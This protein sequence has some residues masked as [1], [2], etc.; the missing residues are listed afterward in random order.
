MT[1]PY[2]SWGRSIPSTPS[3]VVPLPFAPDALPDS[4]LLI[5]YGLG[6]SYGDVCLNNGH[7]LL[8][9]GRMDHFRRFDASTGILECEAGTSLE[10]ILRIGV[11]RG[12]FP[13]VTPGTKFVTVG[14]C[15]ANDV[16]GKNHHRA[17]TFGRHVRSLTL[18]RS[19]GLRRLTPDDPLFA[20]TIGGLGLTGLIVSAEI[21]LRPIESP[22]IVAEKIPFRT[23]EEFDALSR[24]SD[25]TH[26]Y[27]VAWFDSFGGRN[28]RGI[29]FRG[30][31]A[32]SS[33]AAG[34]QPALGAPRGA[35]W[36]PAL[37]AAAPFL[38]PFTV[39][40]FNEAYFR[41]NGR[42]RPQ[43]IDFDPFFYPLDAV[44]DWN[45]IYGKRGFLQ[46]QFVTPDGAGLAP[47]GEVLDRVAKSGLASFLTVI[48]RFGSLPSPGLI[49]FPREGITACFDF[50][51]S[52]S[53]LYAMLDDLDAIVLA[54]GGAIYPAKDARMSA[55]TFRRSFPQ[56]ETFA[57]FIDPRFSS[58]FR[59]RVAL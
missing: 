17:G 45:A 56:W 5:P 48:K 59:R 29:F 12:W 10:E 37:H 16:H 35:G 8:D 7:T 13:P 22:S 30:N 49:S 11:P 9:S 18:L 34:F 1:M 46:Y 33:C 54:A 26:D 44:A 14:G 3:R 36:K 53:G 57:R 32:P 50:A 25:A 39:R 20:A 51:A 24:A 21:A 47:V 55:E 19:D 23:L 42:P 4:D 28:A 41:A 31:H 43:T 40:L 52:S 27:S 38:R 58:S 15:I 2:E 6:R